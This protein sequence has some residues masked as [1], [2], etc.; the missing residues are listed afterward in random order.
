M[1][2]IVVGQHMHSR[3]RLLSAL[4]HDLSRLGFLGQY[5]YKEV[6]ADGFARMDQLMISVGR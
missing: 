2:E 6:P 1:S 5:T 3:G 4:G